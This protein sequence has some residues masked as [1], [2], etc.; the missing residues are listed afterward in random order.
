MAEAVTADITVTVTVSDVVTGGTLSPSG[1]QLGFTESAKTNY[2]AT[3]PNTAITK[4]WSALEPL[5]AST[6]VTLD[7]TALPGPGGTTVTFASVVA[8]YI[9]N[10]G[11]FPVAVGNAATNAFAPGWSETT[12]VETVGPNSRWVKENNGTAYT[13]DSTHKSLMIDPSTHVG[14]VRIILIGN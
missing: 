10:T 4:Q 13:V 8:V 14:A 1:Q 12:H 6:P 9:Y 11:G 7:L 3:A 5:S 2:N